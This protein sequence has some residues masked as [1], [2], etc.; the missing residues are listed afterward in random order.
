[1][2]DRRTAAG[3]AEPLDVGDEAV[4]GLGRERRRE[5][6]VPRCCVIGG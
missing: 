5:A 2:E 4:T 6:G 3:V 1:V